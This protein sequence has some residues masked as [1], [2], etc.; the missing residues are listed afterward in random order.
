MKFTRY[1]LGN[2][3]KAFFLVAL[4]TVVI[5]VIID[6]VGNIRMWLNRGMDDAGEYYLNYLPYIVYLATPIALLIAVVASVGSMAR[7]L[8]LTAMQSAGISGLRIL[9]PLFF[10]GLLVTGGM[11]IVSEKILPDATHRRLELAEPV[12]QKKK[13]PRIKDRSQFAFVGADKTTWYF[14]HYTAISKQARDVVFLVNRKG[15]LAERYDARRLLWKEEHWVMQDGWHR[16]FSPD[17]SMKVRPFKE[18]FLVGLTEV[19]PEDLINDRQTG[20]EMD[21]RMIKQ[22][23]EVLRRSGEDT[24]KLD[25]QWHFKF[26]GPFTN[27]IILLIGAALSH[28]YSRSGGLSQKFGIGLFV[29]FSYYV[30]IKIGLQMGENGVLEPMLAAWLGHIVFGTLALVLLHR[31]LRL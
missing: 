21:S 24:R 6:F 22:R 10:L 3:L 29:V 23:I 8:E 4:G 18:Q 16:R 25:T 1:L 7:H 14:R 9:R 15:A 2:F 13:N 11:F 26:S 28:R 31:S 30:A 5:F 12:Q 17:G 20:D 27:L 19:R